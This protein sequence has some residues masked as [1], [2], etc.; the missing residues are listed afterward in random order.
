MNIKKYISKLKQ[1][2]FKNYKK[3]KKEKETTLINQILEEA[4]VEPNTILFESEGDFADNARALYEYMI[5]KNMNEKYKIIWIVDDPNLYEKKHNV[6][7]ISR[8]YNNKKDLIK[9]YSTV[10]SAK[11]LFFT[12][13]YWYHKRNKEQIIVNL[14]HAIPFKG[15]GR[16]L[17]DIFDYIIVPSDFSKSLFHDFVGSVEAQYII[18]GYPRNDLLFQKTNSI[19]KIIDIKNKPKIIICM[20]TFKQSTYMKDSEIIYPYVLPFITNKTEIFELNEELKAKNIKLIIKIH[21][22]QKTELL[23]KINLSNII[24]LEDK[25]LIKKDLQLYE[26]IGQTDA[27]ITDYSS[28]MFDYMLIDKLI[29]YFVN[30]LEDYKKN[31][32]F[33]VDNL[34]DYM[35]GDKMLS[36]NDFDNFISNVK[37]NKDKYKE[38]RA[39]FVKK[40]FK[41]KKDNCQRLL[42]ILK[43]K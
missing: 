30:D 11:Y 32:G 4:K 12:H 25:D 2:I 9:F 7:F 15:K 43:I 23:N 36:K 6:H 40:M 24:Y 31:R 39:K 10:G 42:D 5:S 28:I 21:H 35:I 1:L 37:N 33:L 16:D 13:P 29:A 38:Q 3:R 19:E 20:T 17:H 27:L 18:C 41:Y 26:I 34:D 14:W 22:L 8:K